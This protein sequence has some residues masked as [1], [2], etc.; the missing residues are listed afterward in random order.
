MSDILY[1]LLISAFLGLAHGLDADHIANVRIF[2]S[3]KKI[4]EFSLFHSAGFLII[5]IPLS[6]LSLVTILEFPLLITSYSIGLLVSGLLLYG[7]VKGKELEIEPKR[8]GLLQG[9]LVI[10]PSKLIVLILALASESIFY[11]VLILLVFIVTSIIS[12]MIFSL[13]N[14][15]PKRFDKIVNIV[16]S[17]G[18]IIYILYELITTLMS[19]H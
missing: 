1:S 5:A 2:K 12:F 15:I 9:A 7:T 17:L 19:M 11:A 13:L 14:L 16:I 8:F 6:L 10:S 18:S 3:V 4:F